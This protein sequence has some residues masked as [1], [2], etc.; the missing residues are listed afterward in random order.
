MTDKGCLDCGVNT[1]SVAAATSCTN[2]PDSKV[3]Q[4]RSTSENDCQYGL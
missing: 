2:C 4:V 3:S 1:Y